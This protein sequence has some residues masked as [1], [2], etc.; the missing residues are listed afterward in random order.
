M[1]GTCD[2]PGCM[3]E[4]DLRTT[5]L[6]KTF[7]YREL[8]SHCKAVWASVS[9]PGKRPGFAVVV[10]MAHK[11][12]LDSYDIF[13]LDEYESFDMRQLVRQCGALDLKYFITFHSLC[14]PDAS[15]KWIGDSKND[16]AAK[17]IEEMNAEGERANRKD[18]TTYREPFRLNST[19]MLEMEN[20]YS[21]ILPQIKDL[22]NA[23]HRQLFLKDSKVVNYL[24]RVEEA[25][26]A[27]LQLGE[28]PAIEALAFVVIEM[29]Q[30]IAAEESYI[31]DDDDDNDNYGRLDYH[32]RRRR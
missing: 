28:Y 23:E 19:M 7:N 11:R 1:D 32:R 17:F 30:R 31:D 24:A 5:E 9:W 13:L 12:H 25:E 26:I 8:R 15:D 27:E 22:V 10:G 16:A 6:G 18:F 3:N 4:I 29:R 21:F 14:Q 2:V 20:P